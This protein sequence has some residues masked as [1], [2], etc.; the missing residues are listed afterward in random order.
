VSFSLSIEALYSYPSRIWNEK[1]STRWLDLCNQLQMYDPAPGTPGV[2]KDATRK[3]ELVSAYQKSVR[4]GLVHLVPWL[5][6]ELLSLGRPE[7]AYCWRRICVTAAE[8]VGFGDP[9]L[10]NFVIV[11]STLFRPGAGPD[12][13]RKV[14]ES[15]TQEMCRTQKS[16]IYCQLSI[17]EEA[18]ERGEIAN[19]L[20]DWERAVIQELRTRRVLTDGGQCTAKEKWAI[21]NNWR[22]DGMLKFQ[23]T[24]DTPFEVRATQ[25]DLSYNILCGL[26]DFCYDKHTRLG[27]AV[28]SRLATTGAIQEFLRKNAPKG[29]K[30]AAVGWALF[31]VEGSRI[32]GGLEDDR[33]SLLEAKAMAGQLG[34]TVEAWK[35]LVQLVSEAVSDGTVNEIRKTILLGYPRQ[36]LRDQIAILQ[37]RKGT[38]FLLREI[39]FEVGSEGGSLA[40]CGK[41]M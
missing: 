8:D 28:C 33:L 31:F 17:I 2:L 14:W 36:E 25:P 11:C 35:E 10:M 30:S 13:L 22:G 19:T 39:V 38:Q 12:V 20:S 40:L 4:R 16:R 3:W 6:S 34:W 9:D 26:P 37:E 32:D 7:W 21:K 29:G 15:L 18:V 24:I 27:R 1:P 5:I 41:E 23:A